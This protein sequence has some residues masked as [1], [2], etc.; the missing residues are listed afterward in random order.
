GQQKGATQQPARA[1][2]VRSP[3]IHPDRSVTFRV[4]APKASEVVLTGEFAVGPQKM[5]KDPQGL[6][7]LTVPPV[8]PDLYEYEISVDGINSIDP[9]N[10]LVK[11]NRAPGVVSS[12]LDVASSG[13]RFFDAKSVPHGKVD[14]RF[15]DSKATRGVRRVR[16]YTPPNYEKLGRLPVLYLLHGAEGD[17]SVWTEFGR[18]HF[19]LDNLIAEKKAQPMVIVTPDGYAYGWDSGVA[20]DKQQADFLKDLTEDLIP[21]VQ[22][23]YKVSTNREQRALAGLSR[24]GAQTLTIGPKHL[25]LFSR[26]AVFSASGN[27]NPETSDFTAKQ[28]PALNAKLSLFWVGMG[29]EDPSFANFTRFGDFLKTNGVKHTYRTIPGAHT[30]IVWRK[31][32]NELAPLLWK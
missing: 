14:V 19:I 23:N 32:L 15:Y 8:D 20:A 25:D 7:T 10:P 12:L 3:E 21:F 4:A 29:T 18:A 16:I 13:P 11:Y 27:M 22:A 6:W 30:W 1:A 31:F 9:R 5:T 28:A 26:L 17:D 2:Q 24:G